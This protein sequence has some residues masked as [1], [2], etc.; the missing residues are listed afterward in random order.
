MTIEELTDEDYETGRRAVE[1]HLI[2]LRDSRISVL[3]RN[4]G[5]VCKEQD[6]EPSSIIRMG[7]EQAMRIAV[8]AIIQNRN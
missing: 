6:G 7:F 5:L 4:N 1:D 3:G 2:Y 8:E